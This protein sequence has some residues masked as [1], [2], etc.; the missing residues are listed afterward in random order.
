MSADNGSTAGS[1]LVAILDELSELVGSARSMPMSASAIVNR[2]EVMELIDSAKDVLPRQIARADG[3]MSDAD[4][5][6][7]K[8][9]AEAEDIVEGGHRRAE[10]IGRASCRAR[11]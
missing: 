2:A 10:E 5:V 11:V 8:A 1:S 4:A 7:D 9:R 6:L 3:V